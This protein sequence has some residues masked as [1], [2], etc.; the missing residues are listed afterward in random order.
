MVIVRVVGFVNW[1]RRL[2]FRLY[3]LRGVL[4]W[5]RMVKKNF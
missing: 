4:K 3:F 2:E 1:N 5:E